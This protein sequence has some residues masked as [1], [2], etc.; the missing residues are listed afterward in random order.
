METIQQNEKYKKSGEDFIRNSINIKS[1]ID[2]AQ[3]QNAGRSKEIP[4]REQV[5][6][7]S[8]FRDLLEQTIVPHLSARDLVT[9]IISGALEVEFGK[10]F[11]LNPGFDKMVKKIADS[12]MV[13]PNLRRQAL[14]VVSQ[15][16]EAKTGTEKKN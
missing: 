5:T 9:I 3:A 6:C 13:D 8:R 11:T 15:V 16:L 14:Q 1:L 7:L 12:L 10:S 4:A 2:G